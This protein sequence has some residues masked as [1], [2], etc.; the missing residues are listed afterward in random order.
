[1]EI[2]KDRQALHQIPELDRDLPKTTAYL[3]Q[4]LS[5]LSCQ[6]FSPIHGAVCAWF[7]FG[8]S[9]A[10][11]FR[12]DADAQAIGENTGLPFASRHPGR[13]H[14]CGH[15]GHMAMVL[16]LARRLDKKTSL[17]KNV[18][19]IFQ[20]GEETSGGAR[21][22]CGTGILQR[23]HVEAIFA[24]HLWPGLEQGVVYSRCQEMMARSC[25]IKVDITGKA[26][27]IANASDGLD[28]LAAGMDF[29]RKACALAG[30]LP[31]QVFR[32]L[33]FGRFES[34]MVCNAISDH[35]RIEGS[36]R[37]FQDDVFYS[38]RAGLVSIG[39]EVERSSGCTVSIYMN[40]E[41]PPIINPP[42]LYNR[43]RKLLPFRELAAP[44]MLTEDFSWYQKSLPGMYFFLGTGTT[45]PLHSDRFTFPEEVL[46]KGADFFEALAET[47]V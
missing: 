37:A 8:A 20:P 28:A 31:K 47:Y 34:G 11:A 29:Y 27:H 13:M 25:E 9:S 39:K 19:L 22:I 38:L 4:R 7:N 1:M 16:E 17:P 21:D 36:L 5:E 3:T 14:A 44:S 12:A 42:K 43:V 33:K 10:I 26:A 23:F 40:D 2:I 15:D 6:V 46:T 41:Y 45:E 18:L 24:M 32:L 35:T 30:A